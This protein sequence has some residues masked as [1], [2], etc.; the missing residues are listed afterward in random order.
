MKIQFLLAMACLCGCQVVNTRV[1]LRD[2][3]ID[4]ETFEKK[5]H[6]STGLNVDLSK[7]DG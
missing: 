3:D 2:D 1:A 6:Q 5:V 4:D 7:N